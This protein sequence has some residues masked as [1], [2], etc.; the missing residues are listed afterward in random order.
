MKQDEATLISTTAL[1]SEES[2]EERGEQREELVERQK[3]W[4]VSYSTFD[5]EG[6]W[7]KRFRTKAEAKAFCKGLEKGCLP[8]DISKA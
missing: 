2:L 8:G 3:K 7:Q 6:Q 5:Q 4:I 1:P